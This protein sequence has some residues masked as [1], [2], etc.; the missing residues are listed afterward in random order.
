MNID[1]YI[2]SLSCEEEKPLDNLISDGGFCS[3]LRTV[4]CIGDSLS[5]GEFETLDQNGGHHYYDIFDYSW[6]QFMARAADITVYNFS[7]GG[8]SAR[9]YIE[10]FAEE[11][12]FWNPEK[13]A[14]HIS[15]HWVLMTYSTI[16]TRSALS[17]T[18]AK[19]ITTET[20]P[21]LRDITP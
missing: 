5:S 2:K 12:D 3:I 4:G 8:M 6:G 18:S 15:W 1:T 21:P 9:Q 7:R 11:K 10:T 20:S 13:N 14:K 19:R 16:M 17:V